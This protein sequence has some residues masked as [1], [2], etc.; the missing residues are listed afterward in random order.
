MLKASSATASSGRWA[1]QPTRRLGPRHRG[2]DETFE[3]TKVWR[4]TTLTEPEVTA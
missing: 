2:A 4:A 3:P 1:P